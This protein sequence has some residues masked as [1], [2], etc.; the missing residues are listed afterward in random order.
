MI[1]DPMGT[2]PDA[3]SP[4]SNGP[5]SPERGAPGSGGP[6]SGASGE[7]RASSS[8]TPGEAM[9]ALRTYADARAYL[10]ALTNVEAMRPARIDQA[11][12]F[13][14]DRMHA[15]VAALDHPQRT[16]RSVH[17]AGS[18]GKGSVCEMTA[19]MLAACGLTVGTYTSPHLVDI[20]E[21]IRINGAWITEEAL[22]DALARVARAAG[23]M[24]AAL[25][26]ITHFE[27][28]TAA[29]FVHFASMAV[30]IAVV[31][32]GMGGLVDATNV[33]VPDV[34]AITAIQREHTQVLGATLPEIARHKAGIMKPGVVCVTIPQPEEVLQVFTTT[35]RDTG[36]I[37]RVLGKDLEFSSRFEAGPDKV[38]HRRVS[39]TSRNRAFEHLIVPLK[40]EHQA[41]N[42]GLALAIVDALADMGVAAPEPAVAAGLAATS[43]N[44]R[45]E[46]VHSDPRIMV[47]GAHNPE[48]IGE[49]VKSLG[50]HVRYDS[51]VVVF[52][53]AADKDVAGMLGAL[54]TG[55]DKVIFTR[56]EGSARAVDP[57]DLLRKFAEVSTKMAQ[58]AATVK[59]ALNL[60]ARAVTRDDLICVTGSFAIAG[61]AKRALLAK[62]RR[63]ADEGQPARDRATRAR[64]QSTII[65]VKPLGPGTRGPN[66][67]GKA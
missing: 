50:A 35:A 9:P 20:R 40:G 58:S 52:G 25:G 54:A 43:A 32:V 42:C 64:E 18:K 60:A 22:T 4:D 16:F 67:R 26:P 24:P 28:M 8:H 56:A 13:N 38:P 19:S 14:L 55:A 51:L 27:A 15:L 37:V 66:S 46:L 39:L 30:D 31:E 53:C 6:E 41:T 49:L 45:M 65:E 10:D 2:P 1:E 12:V 11:H 47:D 48:S 33:L 7:R 21:R 23:A 44:G 62:A 3:Q 17:V 5:N 57:R 63:E 34:T 61:E 36:A 29:S 59:D